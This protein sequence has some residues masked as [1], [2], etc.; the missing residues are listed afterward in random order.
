MDRPNASLPWKLPTSVSFLLSLLFL[1]LLSL[2]NKFPLIF[3][4]SGTYV[5]A[6]IRHWLPG[7]RTVFYSL[8]IFPLH[9]KLSLW[10]V[11]VAQAAV[12]YYVIRIFFKTFSR[13]FDEKQVLFTILLLSLFSSLP[14]FVGQIMP[15]LFSALLILAIVA[16]VLGWDKLSRYDRIA[17]PVLI[18]LFI[19]T[20]LSYLLMAAGTFGFAVLLQLL[21]RQPGTA[22]ARLF[23]RANTAIVAAIA[24]SV[25]IM[26]S[27]NIVAKRGATFAAY[28]NV[29]LMAK[30]IDMGIGMDYL[31]EHCPERPLPI[32]KVLPKLKAV[33]ASADANNKPIG[34]V[35]D[36]FLWAG[37][38]DSLGGMRDVSAYA[39]EI[40]SGA[41]RANPGRFV[42][43]CVRG[44][45]AQM[46]KF[47]LGDDMIRYNSGSLIHDVVAEEFPPATV[48]HLM[49]SRQYQQTLHIDNFRIVSN[50]FL[51]LCVVVIAVFLLRR[52]RTAP[53]VTHCFLILVVGVLL[54][55]TVTGALSAV[56][57]RYGSRVIWLFML[58]GIFIATEFIK[59]RSAGRSTPASSN[60]IST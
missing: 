5:T 34:T 14:W 44:F 36:Y 22:S 19:T 39:S 47:Q 9:M 12:T 51:A 13:Q 17:L 53:M 38:L 49:E 48:Q 57:D 27:I 28:G 18:C 29:M 50:I 58:L 40:S 8:F 52:W 2:W 45:I 7:D 41:I 16:I 26:L 6:A 32:C 59:D 23:S 54:N 42:Q 20:H 11:V 15:D 37:P 35:S 1:L 60:P 46:G 3:S 4:D 30:V 25:V 43:E 24:A 21:T 31:T 33:R 10:P 56:H 55:D